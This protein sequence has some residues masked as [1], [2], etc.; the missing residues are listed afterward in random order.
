MNVIKSLWIVNRRF[1]DIK[2]ILLMEFCV[3]IIVLFSIRYDGIEFNDDNGSF[4]CWSYFARISFAFRL[5]IWYWV[6]KESKLVT[7]NKRIL[8]SLSKIEMTTKEPLPRGN[9]NKSTNWIL[10]NRPLAHFVD[11][12]DF[13]QRWNFVE[14]W[15]DGINNIEFHLMPNENYVI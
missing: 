4:V 12:M 2:N 1:V 8:K 11:E 6:H 10:V 7:R 13:N 14:P 15:T 3:R 9:T 5:A